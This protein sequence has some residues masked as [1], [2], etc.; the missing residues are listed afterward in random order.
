METKLRFGQRYR[1]I[2]PHAIASQFNQS[3][4]ALVTEMDTAIPIGTVFRLGDAFEW[5]PYS[6]DLNKNSLNPNFYDIHFEEHVAGFES[7]NVAVLAHS[8]EHCVEE[9]ADPPGPESANV[10]R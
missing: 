6:I 3:R 5:N 4:T 1:V 10:S 8:L 7:Q 9:I 2:G